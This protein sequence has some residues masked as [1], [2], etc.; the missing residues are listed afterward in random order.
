MKEYGTVLF[1]TFFHRY[2]QQ[3]CVVFTIMNIVTKMFDLPKRCQTIR[4]ISLST[5]NYNPWYGQPVKSNLR[6]M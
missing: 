4:I 6:D 1:H 5:V 3:I 2:G